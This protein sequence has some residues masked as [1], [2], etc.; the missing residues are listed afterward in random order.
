MVQ[1]IRQH[2]LLAMGKS[3]GGSDKK[4]K[5]ASGG[6]V[7]PMKT[8]LPTSPLTDAKRNNGIPGFKKGGKAEC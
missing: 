6:S 7:S 2:K 1:A 4:D 3:V 8:G 5:F